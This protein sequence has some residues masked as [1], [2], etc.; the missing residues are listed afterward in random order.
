MLGTVNASMLNDLFGINIPGISDIIN[1]VGNIYQSVVS[2]PNIIITAIQYGLSLVLYGIQQGF[3]YLINCV[4]DLFRSIAGLSTYYFNGE[5][6][7]GDIVYS[8]L[9]SSTVMSVFW[10]VLIASVF[11]LFVTT[12]IAILKTEVDL[13]KS[14]AKGP[15]FGRAIKS[16]VYFAL[17]PVCC[18]LGVYIANV[19]LQ[20]FDSATSKGADTIASQIF[21][22]ASYDCNR[23]R[24]DSG[25][26][27]TIKN[28][29]LI[30]G[31]TSTSSQADVANAIDD[32]F[33]SNATPNASSGTSGVFSPYIL[34]YDAET[35]TYS[36]NVALETSYNGATITLDKNERNYMQGYAVI[37]RDHIS[38]SS[39]DIT[40][41]TLVFYYYNLLGYNYLIGLLSS[42]IVAMLLLTLIIGVIQRI[43][44][45]SILFVVSPA[46]V[47]TMPL[48]EGARF[49]KW[50]DS[51][52]KRVFS[53][54]GPIIGINLLF[55]ILTYVQQIDVFKP[56]VGINNLFNLVVQILFIV[57]G[58]I[59]V[60]D[61]SKLITELVGSN[62]ALEA[63]ESKKDAVKD[64]GG[65]IGTAGAVAARMG[66][67]TASW[68]G[69]RTANA[70]GNRGILNKEA[71]SAGN[72]YGY[73]ATKS[74]WDSANRQARKDAKQAIKSGKVEGVSF[75]EAP[76]L[77]L[78]KDLHK[79]DDTITGGIRKKM[80]DSDDK[81]ANPLYGLLGD[82]LD[83][84]KYVKWHKDKEKDDRARAKKK[85]QDA[86]DAARKNIASI[87]IDKP[88]R[89]KIGDDAQFIIDNEKAIRAKSTTDFTT[90]RLNEVKTNDVAFEHKWKTT[91][92]GTIP[93][94][95]GDPGFAEFNQGKTDIRANAYANYL[96]KMKDLDV[97]IN[98]AKTVSGKIDINVKESKKAVDY[99]EA[100]RIVEATKQIQRELEK[101]AK[102]N[103]KK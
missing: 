15:I 14:N 78:N 68:A 22:A 31:I 96:G 19:F 47:A 70:W 29:G 87:E 55:M 62:D 93:T 17:V 50:K 56:G 3:F 25:I 100:Q 75:N 86:E 30:P 33:R 36:L 90:E 91:H 42:F 40:N 65:K 97:K 69:K 53:A 76:S 21:N 7:T 37:R 94:R 92:G 41:T 16:I 2:I 54:Y 11:L 39:Y 72:P 9:Q 58:L 89:L 95:P 26:A 101:F 61:F 12:F 52:I 102:D 59:S 13:S 79:L 34:D 85:D 73:D 6:T 45:L 66:A 28:S 35:D 23:A 1:W 60:K 81:N 88:L 82:T 80:K 77:D 103:G 63:G 24:S 46:F 4:Q 32:A 18:I 43:F 74:R 64:L 5:E 20:T 44:E 27:T 84:E 83:D 67:K 8:L 48:D 10:S 99:T 38:F 98:E 49:N 71:M 51:F 57:V